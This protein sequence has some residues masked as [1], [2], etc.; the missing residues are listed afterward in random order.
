[1]R[2]ERDNIMAAGEYARAVGDAEATVG[3]AKCFQR[4]FAKPLGVGSD[5]RRW[6][7]PLLR[8]EDIS[9]SLRATVG[10]PYPKK[11]GDLATG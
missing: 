1:M 8:R 11:P 6:L 5:V 2:R 7:Q 10:N 4:D 3:L 9:P